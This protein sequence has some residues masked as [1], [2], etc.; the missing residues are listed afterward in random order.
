M[1][2]CCCGARLVIRTFQ[3]LEGPKPWNPWKR[4][5]D[6]IMGTILGVKLR[7]TLVLELV[8]RAIAVPR[9]N[10]GDQIFPNSEA[11]AKTRAIRAPNVGNCARGGRLQRRSEPVRLL[12]SKRPDQHLDCDAV[13]DPNR[14]LHAH[15]YRT[16][17]LA[18]LR[19]AIMRDS[20]AP[21]TR[22]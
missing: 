2:E 12:R 21:N 11:V 22:A 10:F 6:P 16:A 8:G 15:R 13:R 20:H 4:P 9:N 17:P 14:S 5:S 1:A 3:Y 7:N 19:G 18:S